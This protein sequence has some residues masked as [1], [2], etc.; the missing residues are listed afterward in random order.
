MRPA[1]LAADDIVTFWEPIRELSLFTLAKRTSWMLP[2]RFKGAGGRFGHQS[3]R[4]PTHF[5][6]NTSTAFQAASGGCF[7]YSS[8]RSRYIFARASSG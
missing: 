7:S 3:G 4:F 1:L 5:F 8:A 2:L 6:L